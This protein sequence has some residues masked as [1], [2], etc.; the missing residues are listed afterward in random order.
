MVKEEWNFS[1]NKSEFKSITAGKRTE[2][3]RLSL[4]GSSVHRLSSTSDFEL[5]C[6]QSPADDLREE[7]RDELRRKG[8]TFAD[9]SKESAKYAS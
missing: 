3:V 9:L 6:L 8:L 2:I 1:I 4:P 7:I 5:Y